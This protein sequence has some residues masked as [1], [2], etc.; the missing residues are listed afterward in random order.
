MKVTETLS[1]L[2]AHVSELGRTNFGC[3][4]STSNVDPL[5]HAY[6]VD[7]TLASYFAK[8]RKESLDALQPSIQS[9]A[10]DQAQERALSDN[11]KQHVS[12]VKGGIYRLDANIKAPAQRLNITGL[13][14]QLARD[15]R[16]TQKEIDAMV[17]RYTAFNKP[18]TSYDVVALDE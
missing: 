16:Y 5:L 7:T 6:H 4:K 18:A 15:G 2:V 14:N 12:L 9:D 11:M 13:K 1:R 10:V 17:E 3:P 8:R